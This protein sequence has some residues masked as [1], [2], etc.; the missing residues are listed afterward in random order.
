MI[1]RTAVDPVI[2]VLAFFGLAIFPVRGL[3][4]DR[5]LHKMPFSSAVQRGWLRIPGSR[6]ENRFMWPAWSFPLDPV[7]I[8]ALLDIWRPEKRLWSPI[9][10]HAA[11]QIVR[12]KPRATADT[13]RGFGSERL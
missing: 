1:P 12:F 9:G 8:D 3:G 2:E 5:N 6:R 11:W 10:V 13:T 4:T 7:G